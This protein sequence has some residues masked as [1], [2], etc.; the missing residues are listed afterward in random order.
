MTELEYLA[1]Q[2]KRAIESEIKNIE[3]AL[4]G[5]KAMLSGDNF[6]G[7]GLSTWTEG[8]VGR[9]IAKIGALLAR[10]STLIE[11]SMITKESE[12]QV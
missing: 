4:S 10:Q 2:N 6:G 3:V 8:Y 7:S 12:V 11:A 9:D 5:L 1:Q